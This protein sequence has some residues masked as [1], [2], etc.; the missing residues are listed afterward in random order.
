[1]ARGD[2]FSEA[3]FREGF[4]AASHRPGFPGRALPVVER[5]VCDAPGAE[6]HVCGCFY[7]EV[8][9]NLELNLYARLHEAA[10][11]GDGSVREVAQKIV[12]AVSARVRVYKRLVDEHDWRWQEGHRIVPCISPIAW[13]S[14]REAVRGSGRFGRVARKSDPVA[15]VELCVMLMGFAVLRRT[16]EGAHPEQMRCAMSV[17]PVAGQAVAATDLLGPALAERVRFTKAAAPMF[18]L[19]ELGGAADRVWRDC[20]RGQDAWERRGVSASWEAAPASAW[21]GVPVVT[22]DA[23]TRVEAPAVWEAQAPHPAMMR[24]PR[25]SGSPR[26][27]EVLPEFNGTLVHLRDPWPR[28]PTYC[29]SRKRARPAVAIMPSPSPP[30]PT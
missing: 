5:L 24:P 20:H 26:A 23:G 2:E 25:I 4:N 8:F 17:D 13:M 28:A 3:L 27:P 21:G 29:A 1:M 18:A 22:Y 10:A 14:V 12:A 11:L 30:Q 6:D 9:L 7:P 15:L 19:R 16:S